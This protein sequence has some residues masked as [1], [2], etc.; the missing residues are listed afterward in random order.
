MVLLSYMFGEYVYFYI[1]YTLQQLT[2]YKEVNAHT[3]THPPTHTH[4]QYRDFSF[5]GGSKNSQ[6]YHAKLWGRSD[7]D[8]QASLERIE[9]SCIYF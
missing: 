3:H 9:K 1:G 4:T 8:H 6:K 7:V 2:E 5:L